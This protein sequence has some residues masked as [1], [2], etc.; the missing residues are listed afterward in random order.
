MFDGALSDTIEH[1]GLCISPNAAREFSASSV[2]KLG[3]ASG[4]RGLLVHEIGDNPPLAPNYGATPHGVLYL[5]LEIRN[6][7]GPAL[8]IGGQCYFHELLGDAQKPLAKAV[9]VA[10]GS[11]PSVCQSSYAAAA[12]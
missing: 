8:A 7:R 9:S 3:F 2:L 6:L 1:Q 5:P 11:A 10:A 12:P 4:A